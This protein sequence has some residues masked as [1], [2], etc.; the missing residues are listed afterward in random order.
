MGEPAGNSVWRLARGLWQEPD[1][2]N[3]S[4][5]SA[6]AETSRERGSGRFADF[7]EKPSFF[8][9]PGITNMLLARG[10]GAKRKRH[11]LC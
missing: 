7:G 11:T 8:S 5:S 4:Q 6:I 3:T 10:Y 9:L 1:Q 2:K